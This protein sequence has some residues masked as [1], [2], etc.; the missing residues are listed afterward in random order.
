MKSHEILLKST[1][2]GD[3]DGVPCTGFIQVMCFCLGLVELTVAL[4][5]NMD[6]NITDEDGGG[7]SWS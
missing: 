5:P 7:E 2:N 6:S 4:R 3:L 1:F